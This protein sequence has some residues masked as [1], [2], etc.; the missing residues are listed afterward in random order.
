LGV[1][2]SCGIFDQGPG[3]NFNQGPIDQDQNFNRDQDCGEKISS[4]VWLHKV[5]HLCPLAQ[6]CV[7]QKIALAY[8]FSI[9][10]CLKNFNQGLEKIKN[11]SL[12]ENFIRVWL[13]RIKFSSRIMNAIEFFLVRSDRNFPDGDVGRCSSLSRPGS[14]QGGC[15]GL[16]SRPGVAISAEGSGSPDPGGGHP[17]GMRAVFGG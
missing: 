17:P 15:V 3:K 16:L 11:Q 8:Y 10:V 4:R 7:S 6:I 5:K 9:K 1:C 13:I 12:P 2:P 14:P